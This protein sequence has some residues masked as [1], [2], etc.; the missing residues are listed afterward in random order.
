MRREYRPETLSGEKVWGEAWAKADLTQLNDRAE[1]LQRSEEFRHMRRYLVAGSRILDV[2]CGTGAW[3]VFL[4]RQGN[5]VVGFDRDANVVCRLRQH[6]PEVSWESGDFESVNWPAGHFDSILSW[7]V[8][9]HYEAGLSVPLRK[10]HELLREGGY[11]FFSVPY[12]NWRVRGQPEAP[13]KSGEQFYQ[14]RFR[15][16]E[17]EAALRNSGF[18]PLELHPIS[19]RQGVKRMV[20]HDL[21]L[22]SPIFQR[23]AG[24]LLYLLLPKRLVGHMLFA[25]ARRV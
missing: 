8:F 10:A 6:V 24:G 14:Y 3:S 16:A 19:K 25:V 20:L 18:Q 17:V 9:E 2:G 23:L 21:G 5:V 4:Q 12:E 13:P 1:K 15:P 22:K 7:G 11:L